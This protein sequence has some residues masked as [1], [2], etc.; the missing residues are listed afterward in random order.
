MSD[1]VEATAQVSAS[2]AP[3]RTVCDYDRDWVTSEMAQLG[4][5]GPFLCQPRAFAARM[6]CVRVVIVGGDRVRK[7]LSATFRMPCSEFGA[8]VADAGFD[9]TPV[10]GPRAVSEVHN[11]GGGILCGISRLLRPSPA[12]RRHGTTGRIAR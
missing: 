6:R 1:V 8:F 11:L 2:D 10:S 9:S 4:A 7:R 3:R 12:L 5:A